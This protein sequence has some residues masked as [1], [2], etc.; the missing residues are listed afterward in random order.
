MSITKSQIKIRICFY[1]ILK[2]KD[3]PPI[4]ININ[5]MSDMEQKNATKKTCFLIYLALKQRCF[6]DQ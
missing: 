6:E 2:I 4:P 5:V 3:I 1:N